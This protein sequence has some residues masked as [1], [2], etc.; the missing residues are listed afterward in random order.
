MQEI[1]GSPRAGQEPSGQA[2]GKRMSQLLRHSIIALKDIKHVRHVPAAALHALCCT[3]PSRLH[4]CP[5]L[6]V[7]ESCHLSLSPATGPA[8]CQLADRESA[9]SELLEAVT[10]CRRQAVYYCAPKWLCSSSSGPW[11]LYRSSS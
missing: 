11:W 8:G 2:T 10:M 5:V 7:L 1:P 9:L 4:A 6:S 3:S